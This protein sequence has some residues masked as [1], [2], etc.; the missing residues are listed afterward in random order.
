MIFSLSFDWFSWL[1]INVINFHYIN[2]V[3]IQYFSCNTFPKRNI[4][5]FRLFCLSCIIYFILFAGKLIYFL[6]GCQL[7]DSRVITAG[8]CIKLP[9]HG[10]F[11]LAATICH[12]V[13]LI[14]I[15]IGCCD[16][17]GRTKGATDQLENNQL[18]HLPW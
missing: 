3:I 7:L 10:S 14:I 8:Q 9:D 18:S 4:F 13:M 16:F 11:W 12:C 15:S 6:L 17:R 2:S 1:S 5:F